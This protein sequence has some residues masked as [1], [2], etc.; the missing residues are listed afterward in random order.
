[1]AFLI[2]VNIYNKDLTLLIDI[3]GDISIGPEK[4]GLPIDTASRE[5]VQIRRVYGN[6]LNTIDRIQKSTLELQVQTVIS[7]PHRINID[8]DNIIPSTE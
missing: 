5:S 2:R 4:P 3:R 7:Q 8:H 6:I 1:M